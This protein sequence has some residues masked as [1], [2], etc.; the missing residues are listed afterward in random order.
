MKKKI[1]LS[2]VT[3]ETWSRTIVLLIA[4][5]NQCLAI[6]GKGQIEI[7]ENDIY[8]LCSIIFTIF[9]AICGWWKNN[10]FSESAQEGDYT[11]KNI[12]NL[13]Q[14]QNGGGSE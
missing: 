14:I 8:Q 3:A 5:I 11:M 12:E 13:N 4:L 6:F 2:G 9:S 10:S 1:N 7:A